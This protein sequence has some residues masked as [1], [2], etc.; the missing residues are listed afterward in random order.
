MIGAGDIP[1]IR[2]DDLELPDLAF[3]KLDIEGYEARAL[4]GAEQTLLRFKPLVMFE[5]KPKKSAHFGDPRESHEFLES[6]GA[7]P[8]AC[9]GPKQIDWLYGF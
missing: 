5:D 4:R 9:I 6:L 8:I 3:F 1:T 2:I 7:K